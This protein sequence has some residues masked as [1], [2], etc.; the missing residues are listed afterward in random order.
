MT[1]NE[2]RSI[3]FRREREALTEEVEF[4]LSLGESATAIAKDLGYS[5]P[6]SL[7]RRM[8][9]HGRPDLAQAFERHR[10]KRRAA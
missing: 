8:W 7:A 3:R 2:I 4:L 1:A 5:K 6:E 9:R 10:D